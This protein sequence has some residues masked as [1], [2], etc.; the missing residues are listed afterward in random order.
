MSDKENLEIQALDDDE[1]EDVNGGMLVMAT[2]NGTSGSTIKRQR[3]FRKRYRMTNAMMTNTTGY[4]PSDIVYRGQDITIS[5]L[6]PIVEKDENDI[7]KLGTNN[8]AEMYLC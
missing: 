2:D 6:G 7:E 1:L 8:P 4:T 3:K 5:N